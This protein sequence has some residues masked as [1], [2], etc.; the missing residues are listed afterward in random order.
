MLLTYGAFKPSDRIGY[1]DFQVGLPAMLICIEMCL[2]SML[3]FYA[4]SYREAMP[5]EH[6]AAVAPRHKSDAIPG[7]RWLRETSRSPKLRHLPA[8]IIYSAMEAMNPF[9]VLR[10]M[11]ECLDSFGQLARWT[12]GACTH[13]K[14]W[15]LQRS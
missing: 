6:S 5:T 4:F 8:R 15:S 12:W 3:H 13:Y 14:T 10:A 11:R 1:N 2:F 9:D 7:A